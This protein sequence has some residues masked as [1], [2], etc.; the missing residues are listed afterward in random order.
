MIFPLFYVAAYAVAAGFWKL[1]TDPRT[2]EP[3][4]EPE[5]E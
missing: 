5:H 1:M 4:K 3:K 2:P